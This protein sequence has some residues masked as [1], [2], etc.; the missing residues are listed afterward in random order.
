MNLFKSVFPY[1]TESEIPSDINDRINKFAFDELPDGRTK[2]SGFALLTES[3]RVL[4]ANGKWLFK[5]VEHS[6]KSN[7]HSVNRLYNQ[8]VQKASE[9]GRELTKEDEA[10]HREQAEREVLKYAPISECVVFILFDERAGRVLCSG[11]TAK[12]CENALKKLRGVLNGLDTLPLTYEQAGKTLARH[13]AHHSSRSTHHATH[14]PEWLHI[15]AH[16]KVVATDDGQKATFDGIDV[17]DDGL[18]DVI[19]GMEVRAVEMELVRRNEAGERAMLASFV[20]HLPEKGNLH[21]KGYDFDGS[22]AEKSGDAAHDYA[23]T[24]HIIANDVWRVLLGL[25]VFFSGV[26]GH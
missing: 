18:R 17:R 20:V 19:A 3:D 9:S 25:Q 11:S 21:L 26:A 22:R 24:M 8:R 10:A 23:A 1:T 7:S 12:K 14:L 15:P 4:N 5:Y 13:L 6:R 2:M 16:G